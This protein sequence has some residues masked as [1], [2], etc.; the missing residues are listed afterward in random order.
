LEVVFPPTPDLYAAIGLLSLVTALGAIHRARNQ[1]YGRRYLALLTGIPII[2]FIFYYRGVISRFGG[3]WYLAVEPY[4]LGVGLALGIL[5]GS[6]AALMPSALRNG[7]QASEE[8]SA[9]GA[10]G[11]AVLGL[12]G[13]CG[14]SLLA[15]VA[16]VGGVTVAS[17]LSAWSPF[18]LF[19]SVGILAVSLVRMEARCTD[20]EIEEED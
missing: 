15:A 13:C 16:S 9:L 10:A 4:S 5:G 8:G 6:V 14:G 1:V 7:V 11:I 20:C 17:Q 2:L 3:E 18:L 12:V 19:G